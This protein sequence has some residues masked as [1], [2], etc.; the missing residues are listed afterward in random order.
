MDFHQSFIP[1]AYIEL[2][3]PPR[4]LTGKPGE[5]KFKMDENHLHIWPRHR[6]MLI[7]L[8]NKV[9]R[10][11]TAFIIGTSTFSGI[12]RL[13]TWAANRSGLAVIFFLF[14][15]IGLRSHFNLWNAN[16]IF[17]INCFV[18]SLFYCLRTAPSHSPSLPPSLPSKLFRLAPKQKHGSKNISRQLS[19]WLERRGCWMIS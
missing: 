7:G 19:N 15:K 9:S 8:P 13:C 14:A 3:M 4:T 11:A 1:D 18:L 10:D 5:S 2:H 16:T 17:I 12:C 6:F